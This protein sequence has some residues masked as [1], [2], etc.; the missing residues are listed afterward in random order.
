V[1]SVL[2]SSPETKDLETKVCER[3]KRRGKKINVY[4]EIERLF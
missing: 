1:R 4:E 3:W 2:S